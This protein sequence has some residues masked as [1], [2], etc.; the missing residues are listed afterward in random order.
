[1]IG[2]LL[3]WT[4]LRH[5]ARAP[6]LALLGA[7]GI[8]LGVAVFVAVQVANRT[9]VRTFTATVDAIAGRSNLEITG[10]SS[11]LPD[12]LYPAVR[13]L[14]GIEAAT[15]LL[16]AHVELP[17]YAGHSAELV[18]VDS[19]SNHPF[20]SYA[21]AGYE[22]EAA[23]SEPAHAP[24]AE[25]LQ[26]MADPRGALVP[27]RFARALGIRAGDSLRILVGAKLD[28]L[29]IHRLIRFEGAL[30]RT[31]QSLLLLDLAAAQEVSGKVGRIDRIDLIAAQPESAAAVLPAALAGSGL[32]GDALVRR[33][34]ARIAQ[35]ETM[36][37]AFRLNLTALSLVSLFVGMFLISNTAITTVVRRRWEIGV[38][39][40]LGAPGRLIRNLALIETGVLSIV[41]VAAGLGLGVLLAR[42]VLGSIART[43]SALYIQVAVRELFVEPGDLALA[44]AVGLGAA[45]VAAWAPAQEAMQIEPERVLAEGRYPAR[46]RLRTGRLLALS[47]VAYALAAGIAASRLSARHPF[48]GFAAALLIL[49]AGALAAPAA[50]AGLAVAVARA[51]PTSVSL[52]LAAGALRTALP[53]A[54]VTV[55]ALGSAL[56]MAIG[57]SIM[58][59]SFRRTVDLWVSQTVRADLYVAPAAAGQ[60]TGGVTDPTL[61]PEVVA[62]AQRLPGLRALDQLRRFELVVDG[63][64]E[65]GGAVR[66]DVLAQESTFLFRKG[67]ARSILKLAADRDAILISEPFARHHRLAEG[68]TLR[69]DTPSGPA[70][71]P[72]AGVFY[73]YSSDAGIVLIDW[74]LYRR[75]WRDPA[76]NS[77]AF[78]LED[79]AAAAQVRAAFLQEVGP[80][81]ALLIRSHRDIREAALAQFDQTFAVTMTLKLI[82]LIVAMAGV[83][84]ALTVSV[85][86]RR[87]EFG[88]LRAVGAAG[89]QVRRVVLGEALLIGLAS[90]AVGAVTG[91][92]LALLL[93]FVINKQFFGWTILWIL[94]P[95]PLIEAL[96]VVTGA[97]LLAAW[98]PSRAALRT[99]PAASLRT[100]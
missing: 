21:I 91:I 50:A 40:A 65:R 87:A 35:V 1:M 75:W 18:G 36:L 11:G 79:P 78:Y 51:A 17:D 31:G 32:P 73:D 86:E 38:L 20:R 72:I 54:A 3:V 30:E 100:E 68:D 39:R 97:S 13:R 19:F 62:A 60:R 25:F 59:E 26:W 24:N 6:G 57:V 52:R 85:A 84:F 42:V 89:A 90:L 93:V 28:T 12:T 45:A 43:V 7:L 61:S 33:P 44:G 34:Q 29:V 15:P 58:I 69:V 48:A 88:I 47:G 22:S 82:T 53:R 4:G 2:R 95:R 37:A 92:G 77:L 76:I 70:A 16:L 27:D 56:A 96:A 10:G 94:T 66:F 67:D 46:R 80:A 49:L 5:A 74:S 71:F 55:A 8:A 41:G 9:V 23:V 63:K 64:R 98:L 99:D 81:H 14:P 83:F